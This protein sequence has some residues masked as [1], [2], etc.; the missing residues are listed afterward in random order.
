MNR[1]MRFSDR[2]MGIFILFFIW[3]TLKYFLY[4]GNVYFPYPQ[5]AISRLFDLLVSGEIFAD[6]KS[7]FTKLFTGY[8]YASVFGIAIGLIIGSSKKL[9][10]R[11]EII[12]DFFRSIPVTTLFPLFILYF[13]ISATTIIAMVF[14]SCIFV[15]LLN[16][17][18]GISYTNKSYFNTLQLF[19]ANK[20][21]TFVHVSLPASLPFIFVG[22]RTS[23]SFALIVEIVSEM[24]IGLEK[25]LGSRIYSA[26]ETYSI[27]DAYS[28]ILLVGIIGFSLNKMFLFLEKKLVHWH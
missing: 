14:T 9:Y 18:Y 3:W 27:V 11:L 12:F 23:I 8:A 26:H 1:L 20:I 6:I 28:L 24:F 16:V 4:R 13:G 5:E 2:T 10:M 19:G 15:I 21:Q 17:A 25:G 22:L 7:T